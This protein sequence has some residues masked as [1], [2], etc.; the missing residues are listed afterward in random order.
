MAFVSGRR[1]CYIYPRDAGVN[2]GIYA[3]QNRC[4]LRLEPA[5]KLNRSIL[6]LA[7]VLMAITSYSQQSSRNPSVAN[8]AKLSPESERWVE[9]TLKN[10]SLDE[11]VRAGLRGMG[12][13]RIHVDG[14]P[15]LP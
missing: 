7:T 9:Q 15:R 10:M 13:R 8:P 3:M 4:G 2:S 12:L 1:E 14:E 5:R 6:L 11:K